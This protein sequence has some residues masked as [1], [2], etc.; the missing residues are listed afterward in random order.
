M[1]RSYLAGKKSPTFK[2]LK[3]LAVLAAEA[4][5]ND[6]SIKSDIMIEKACRDLY[7]ELEGEELELDYQV[8]SLIQD[9]SDHFDAKRKNLAPKSLKEMA[10]VLGYM[11]SESPRAIIFSWKYLAEEFLVMAEGMGL[12]NCRIKEVRPGYGFIAYGVAQTKKS[13]N[14]RRMK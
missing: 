11:W 9:V 8:K 10:S 1:I 12:E 3:K 13:T 2:T 7:I 4:A 14:S 6:R 5:S